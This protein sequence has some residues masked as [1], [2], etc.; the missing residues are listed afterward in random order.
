MSA[1]Q[2]FDLNDFNL[3]QS[4][5]RT[6]AN[7]WHQKIFNS[8]NQI[9]KGFT[10]SGLGLTQATLNTTDSTLINSQSTSDFSW[11]TTKAGSSNVTIPASAFTA[12]Q[13]NFIEI[14][15]I[16]AAGVPL[17]RVFQNAVGNNGE[18]VEFTQATNTQTTLDIEIHVLPAPSMDVEK[19]P[20]AFVDVDSLGIITSIM[21]KRELM[22]RL[23]T[24]DNPKNDYA[25]GTQNEPSL[26]VNMSGVAT[27][28]SAG[29][30]VTF[31]SG[32]TAIAATS[33]TSV[34]TINTLN[35]DSFEIGD[36]LTGSSSGAT[37]TVL[38]VQHTFTGG[39][40][41]IASVKDMFDALATEIKKIKGT[42]F[43]FE[44]NE[45]NLTQ[46]FTGDTLEITSINYV[47]TTSGN[48]RNLI[49]N[50][51][52]VDRTITLPLSSENENKE[53]T[54]KKGDFAATKVIITGTGGELIE[55]QNSISLY[56]KDDFLKV[57]STNGQWK[58]LQV[59][60]Y[61]NIA[62]EVTGT[63]I[64][65]KASNS[66]FKFCTANTAFTFSNVVDTKVIRLVVT[67]TGAFT[68]TFP[69]TISWD[70]DSVPTNTPN[71]R[72]DI[73]EFVVVN[74]V[75]YGK[76]LMTNMTGN[77]P[78]GSDGSLT[79][80]NGQTIQLTAG[81]IK[82]Y[83][84]LTIN[85]GGIL[86]ITGSTGAFTYIGC[87]GN[88][89]MNGSIYARESTFTG[90]IGGTAPDGRALT[91]TIAQ[92]AGGTGGN[93]GNRGGG[94][95]GAGGAQSGGHGGGGGGG[96][97]YNGTGYNGGAGGAG[98]SNGAAGAGTSSGA[99]GA[100]ISS[101]YGSSGATSQSP[102]SAYTGA[103]GG[104][105]ANG[106]G[107]GGGGG[108][109]TGAQN[110]GG[111]GGGGGGSAGLSGKCL[112][113]RVKGNVSGTGTIYI[114]GANGG[115]GGTSRNYNNS[116]SDNGGGGGGGAG[117]SGGCVFLKCNGTNAGTVNVT[118][119]GGS[120]GSGGGS[121]ANVGAAGANGNAGSYTI[122]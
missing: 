28:F 94:L 8:K 101:S 19:L 29:E 58:V 76:R 59:K 11:F 81:S 24:L 91:Y 107:G 117:G 40:T 75:V 17:D 36:T 86:E 99:G 14:S 48:L 93:G 34:L 53:I 49:V 88:L 41:G 65:F 100:S 87:S 30:I 20:I 3:E 5:Q 69:S 6:D 108:Y 26:I 63:V 113:I 112:Y 64:D 33:G 85:T 80:I 21:D 54:I 55:N 71:A 10:I 32:A 77:W 83:T 82:D 31:T 84:N 13:R 38:T 18:G 105:G 97:A 25:W 118:T 4:T 16:E 50:T 96:G 56:L 57:V 122:L 67:N 95:G 37:G 102:F 110:Y 27:P 15:I 60:S 68:I 119:T 78:Y 115:S 2:R 109:T 90:Y 72:V 35:S 103:N 12:N 39:D 9:I 89:V 121:T 116:M 52:A 7:L 45:N 70:N 42:D 23:G 51:G 46:I 79:I 73:F 44:Q 66:Y 43:W 61:N 1:A 104:N 92:N 22:F 62:Y 120:G 111:A 74:G 47:I 114:N 106:G 98:G